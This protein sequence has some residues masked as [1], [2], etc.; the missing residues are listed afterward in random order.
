MIRRRLEY[1]VFLVACSLVA[2]VAFAGPKD[3][4]ETKPFTEWTDKEVDKLLRNDSPW[5]IRLL[6]NAPSTGAGSGAG[7]SGASGGGSE[8]PPPIYISWYARPIR[9][10]VARY[11]MLQNPNMPKA[12]LDALVNYK[13]DFIEFM[14]MDLP[15][16]GGARGGQRGG[17]GET[18]GGGGSE[19]QEKFKQE[20]YLLKKDNAKIPLE[21]YQPPRSRGTAGFLK[22]PKEIDGKPTITA[23]DKEIRLVIKIQDNTYKFVFKLDKMVVKGNLE[24]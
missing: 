20:T 14:L 24:I 16:S 12:Q 21:T 19:A 3:F 6:L 7:K 2:L 18:G 23:D 15:S 10:A 5:T 4:W 9:E 17:R 13:S 8:G 11:M 1:A 22:F